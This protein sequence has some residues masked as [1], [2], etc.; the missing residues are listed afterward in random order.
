VSFGFHPYFGI[1]SLPREKWRLEL[2]AMRRLVVDDRGIPTGRDKS[3]DRFDA[4]LGDL[5]L[6][7]GFTALDEHPVFSL[8]GDGRRITLEFLENYHYA[9]VFVP[10]GKDFVALEPMTAPTSALTNGRGLRLVEPGKEFRAALRI[11]VQA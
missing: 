2:P 6:D 1:T 4:P 3:F 11:G 5:N 9:Q 7:A 8:S 10:K